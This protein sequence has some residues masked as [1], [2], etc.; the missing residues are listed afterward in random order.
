MMSVHHM[1]I[2]IYRHLLLNSFDVF[3]KERGSVPS[4][5]M[6]KLFDRYGNTFS[7]KTGY[8][9]IYSKSYSKIF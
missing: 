8:D 1:D 4:N 2:M 6:F 7:L 3:N 5:E 9:T